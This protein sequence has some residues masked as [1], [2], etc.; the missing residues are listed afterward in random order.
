MQSVSSNSLDKH[1][2]ITD[3]LSNFDE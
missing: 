2:F 1:Q 3:K